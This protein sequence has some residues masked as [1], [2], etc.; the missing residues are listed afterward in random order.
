[1]WEREERGQLEG[2]CVWEGEGGGLDVRVYG[3][4]EANFWTILGE[5][6][7]VRS[8]QSSL[9]MTILDSD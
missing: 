3:V 2:W 9:S 6:E 1:M 4:H 7:D 5:S 8:T